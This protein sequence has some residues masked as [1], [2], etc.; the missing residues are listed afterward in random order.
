MNAFNLENL[1]ID[2]LSIKQKVSLLS[3]LDEWTSKTIN[4]PAIPAAWVSDGPHGL[5]KSPNSAE[6][7]YGDQYPSICYPTASALAATWNTELLY[8]VGQHLAY[9]CK[10]HNVDVLLGPGV[11]IKR[12]PTGGRN[13]EYFSEDPV[14]AG[15]LA[16][17]YINGMQDH[18]VG[19]SLKHF[20]VNSQE[21]RRMVV[22]SIVDERTLRE[23]YLR[24]FEIAISKAKPWTVMASYNLVN[25]DDATANSFLLKKVLRDE[26]QYDGLVMSD[27]VAVHDRVQALKAGLDL[28]MPGNGGVNDAKI[29]KALEDGIVSEQTIDECLVHFSTFLQRVIS[30]R[31]QKAPFDVQQSHSFAKQVASESYVLL[32]NDR[33]IL[34]IEL[35]KTQSIALIG[36]FS[37]KPRTQGNGSSE[38][39]PTQLDTLK[40]EFTK[41]CEDKVSLNYA[42]GYSL[43]ADED[44]QYIA[45][46]VAIA[47]DSNIAIV[48]VGLPNHYE[49]EGID[50]KHIDLPPA[51]VALIQAIAKVQPNVIVVL[52]NGAAISMPWIDQIPAVLETWLPGQ[53]GAGA[54]ADML[55]GKSCPSGKLA[56]TF[57]MRLEDTPAFIDYPGQHRELK[58]SEGLFVGYK[59]YQKR[60]IEPLFPFGFGLSY[61]QFG[62]QKLTCAQTEVTDQ[63][64]VTLSVTVKNAGDCD[65]C[66]VAQ[67]Y[68]VPPKSPR[69]LD[70][71]TKALA[72]F[73]KISLAPGEEK[74][75][76][77]T[78]TSR[79]FSYY[80]EQYQQ[81][82]TE[83]GEYGIE[84][85]SSSAHTHLT[86]TIT[87][88][89]TQKLTVMFDKRTTLGECIAHEPIK[90]LVYGLLKEY[91]ETMPGL[92]IGPIIDFNITNGFF[93]DM[94]IAKFDVLSRGLIS[95]A[96]VERFIEQ[97]NQLTVSL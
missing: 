54:I 91:F 8:N 94:P 30:H 66:E 41:V 20:A 14:L 93:T 49:S 34:P 77:F 22:D 82:I 7:G 64:T 16:A 31:E 25:G 45:E 21:T 5:R 38:V 48:H 63:D 85:G 9:E 72:A 60:K 83:S 55:I 56:E 18:G 11:N 74:S 10:H 23:T 71:P 43:A 89:S 70:R 92:F 26:W 58:F 4:E 84:V 24:A 95:Q 17:G 62:Y 80:D 52:T 79:D 12:S 33:R 75:V 57:P 46:A 32:K 29:L 19:T 81:W 88:A 42:Q 40:E 51:Q 37:I 47:Q 50:R 59:W 65:G 87:I 68:V 27:W 53:A 69:G 78:L 15:E 36:E 44:E 28:E 2:Q 67:V 6:G 1:V 90:H 96:D 35:S 3:G 76:D 13:F 73:S 39:K 86:Q 61:T 97:A